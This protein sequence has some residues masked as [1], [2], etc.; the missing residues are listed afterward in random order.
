MSY[1][2]EIL[3]STERAVLVIYLYC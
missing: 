2:Q 1:E 3:I